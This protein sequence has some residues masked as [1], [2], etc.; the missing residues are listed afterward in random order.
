ME[1][2]SYYK[3]FLFKDLKK[4]LY[5]YENYSCYAFHSNV[6]SCSH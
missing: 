4:N 1:N 6:A 5:N 2:V 3:S